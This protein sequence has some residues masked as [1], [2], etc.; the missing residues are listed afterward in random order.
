[1]I[2]KDQLYRQVV[3]TNFPPRRIVSLVPSQTEL[4]AD[5]GLADSV[6]GLTKFCVHPSDWRNRKTIVGGT[7]QIHLDRIRDLQPDLIIANQEEND[8]EQV[9]TLAK[10]FPVWVSKVVDL[11]SALAMI[12]EVGTI[13]DRLPEAESLETAIS[14]SFKKLRS[15]TPLSAA[16]L[17]WRKPYMVS[18]GDTFIHAMMKRAGFKNVFADQ[19]RYPEVSVTD[20]QQA[21]PDVI[22]LS[23][24][25]FPFKE[26]HLVELQEHCPRAVIRLVD[27]ELFSW[28]GS[29]LLRSAGYFRSLF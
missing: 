17:I 1:V 21:D 7:K 20:L 13:C 29:R 25:P 10:D 5:L 26:E 9:E 12:L 22:L 11:E 28:Y 4:L 6:V 24:E 19:M 27:G 14:S 23:S 18:G 8:K 16:Y 3:L 2:Y 15:F